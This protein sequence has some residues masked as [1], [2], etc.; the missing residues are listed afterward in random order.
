MITTMPSP[1]ARFDHHPK[2]PTSL[3][4]HVEFFNQSEAAAAYQWEVSRVGEFASENLAIEFPDTG[5]FN[6]SL[7]AIHENNCKDTMNVP[8]D[9]EPIVIYRSEER[10]VGK[11]CNVC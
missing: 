1:V 8:I 11:E 6:V 4:R 10:R 5:I 2:N 9:I 7:I 3:D